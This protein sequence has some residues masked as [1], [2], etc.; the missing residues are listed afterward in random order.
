MGA[1]AEG[2]EAGANTIVYSPGKVSKDSTV[3]EAEQQW[4]GFAAEALHGLK[5]KEKEKAGKIHVKEMGGEVALLVKC[6]VRKH[7]DLSSDSQNPYKKSGVV[8]LLVML[9]LGEG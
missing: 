8:G 3:D 2:A 5:E 6:L 7:E 4:A 1:E 9:A